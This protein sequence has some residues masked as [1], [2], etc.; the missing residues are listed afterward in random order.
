MGQTEVV[1]GHMVVTACAGFNGSRLTDTLP[2][3]SHTVVGS[4]SFIQ[5]RVMVLPLS[6]ASDD[7]CT[8][9]KWR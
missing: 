9:A 6:L 1:T 7:T 5:S 4:G 8:F 2:A 3:D